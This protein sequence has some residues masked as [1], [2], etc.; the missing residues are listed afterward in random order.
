[1]RF[2]YFL[3]SNIKNILNR[4]INNDANFIGFDKYR[5]SGAYHWN[6]LKTNQ[7]YRSLI[8]FVAKYM[9]SD[10]IEILSLR[11]LCL[12]QEKMVLLMTRDIIL[13]SVRL[14]K[15]VIFK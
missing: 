10:N 2:Y 4:L 5:K 3:A 6:E 13:L 8:D 1:L 9:K 15:K 14:S 7:E 11:K 12:R